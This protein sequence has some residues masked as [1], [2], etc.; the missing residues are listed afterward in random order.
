VASNTHQLKRTIP[1]EPRH[2][3]SSWSR[4]APIERRAFGIEIAATQE[5]ALNDVQTEEKI[6]DKID[7]PPHLTRS[8]VIGH[9][10]SVS[11]KMSYKSPAY[12][13]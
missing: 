1:K 4:V 11:R 9:R 7:S 12:E 2:G 5:D 10:P 8:S 3:T 6:H 13:S